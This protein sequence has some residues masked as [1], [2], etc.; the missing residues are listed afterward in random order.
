MTHSQGALF[1]M[2]CSLERG[3]A[4]TTRTLDW[5]WGSGGVQSHRVLQGGAPKG[6]QLSFNFASA[7]DPLFKASKAPFLT[8]RVATFFFSKKHGLDGG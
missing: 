2:L 6:R 5:E 4:R 1:I 3:S 7:P 8:L